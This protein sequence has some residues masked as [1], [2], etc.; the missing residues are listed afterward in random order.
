MTRNATTAAA[1]AVDLNVWRQHRSDRME[2]SG[3]V[4]GGTAHGSF[5]KV[6]MRFV[7]VWSCGLKH[8][9]PLGSLGIEVKQ[10]PPILPGGCQ[11]DAGNTWLAPACC[12]TLSTRKSP[13]NPVLSPHSGLE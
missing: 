3:A 2:W 10:K 8:H 5:I 6:G 13:A 4:K 1:V 9:R 11:D 12:E 7:T